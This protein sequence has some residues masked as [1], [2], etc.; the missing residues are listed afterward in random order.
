MPDIGQ[1]HRVI[2]IRH[3]LRR[4]KKAGLV[5]KDSLYAQEAISNIQDKVLARAVSWYK[6]GARRGALVILEPRE[7]IAKVDSVR[8]R[9]KLRVKVGSSSRTVKKSTYRLS[10][11][12]LDFE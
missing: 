2:G 5:E 9:K 1:Q 7:I 6:I 8:W 10:S 11:Q 12:E 3:V 4:L